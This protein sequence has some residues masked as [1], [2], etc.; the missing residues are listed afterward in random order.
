M[1]R[2]DRCMDCIRALSVISE[3]MIESSLCDCIQIMIFFRLVLHNHFLCFQLPF[4]FFFQSAVQ[5]RGVLYTGTHYTWV[6]T[7]CDMMMVSNSLH[8]IHYGIM[9]CKGSHCNFNPGLK[10]NPNTNAYK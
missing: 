7:V 8:F 5:N 4:F 6:N 2:T 10:S 1:G 9:L 3:E